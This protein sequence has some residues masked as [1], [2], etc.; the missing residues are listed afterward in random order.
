MKPLYHVPFREDPWRHRWVVVLL[1]LSRVNLKLIDNMLT[2][3]VQICP[4]L[5]LDPM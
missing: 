3:S 5:D 4:D 2:D 1:Y